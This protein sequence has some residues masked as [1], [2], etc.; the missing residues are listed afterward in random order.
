MRSGWPHP[1]GPHMSSQ[2]SCP[3]MPSPAWLV[4]ELVTCGPGCFGKAT[5]PSQAVQVCWRKWRCIDAAHGTAG[6][7][8]HQSAIPHTLSYIEFAWICSLLLT[9]LTLYQ[10]CPAHTCVLLL[11]WAGMMWRSMVRTSWNLTPLESW[12]TF[13]P[14]E[15]GC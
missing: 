4:D 6:T 7:W 9:L 8:I 13:A 1:P 5:C 3:A 15:P 11:D 10:G 2:L 14:K 12:T